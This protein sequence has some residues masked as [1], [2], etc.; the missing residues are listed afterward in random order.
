M[1]LVQNR[2]KQP[3]NAAFCLLNLEGSEAGSG[4]MRSAPPMLM[5]LPSRAAWSGPARGS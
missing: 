2:L 4:K 5:T 1:A 3:E